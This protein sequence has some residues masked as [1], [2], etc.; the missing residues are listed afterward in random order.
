MLGSLELIDTTKVQGDLRTFIT[1]F[2]Q[3]VVGFTLTIT[4]V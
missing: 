1:R 3:Y 2:C 4:G